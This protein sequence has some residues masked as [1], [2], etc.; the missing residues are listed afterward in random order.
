[1]GGGCHSS[2]LDHLA[3]EKI[4]CNSDITFIS[5]QTTSTTLDE[6]GSHFA[7]ACVPKSL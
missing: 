6:H 5:F 7:I 3:G 1:M 4:F 2:I